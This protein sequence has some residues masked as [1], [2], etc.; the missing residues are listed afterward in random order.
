MPARLRMMKLNHSAQI[1]LDTVSENCIFYISTTYEFSHSQ[2]PEQNRAAR[3]NEVC[4]LLRCGRVCDFSVD[5]PVEHHCASTSACSTGTSVNS[6]QPSASGPT[7][8]WAVTS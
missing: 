7:A 4:F 2:D 3:Q 5:D 1:R 8:A 6:T